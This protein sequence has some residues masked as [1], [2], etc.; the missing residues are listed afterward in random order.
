MGFLDDLGKSLNKVGK[1]TSEMASG[2]KLKLEITKHKSNI[3]KK[4][5]ELGARVYFLN[6]EGLELDESISEM[7]SAIDDM[8]LAIDN[9]EKEIADIAKEQAAEPAANRCKKCG[10]T[11]AEDTKFCGSCGDK[12]EEVVEEVVEGKKLCPNCQAEVGEAKF[13][14]SCG[15]SLE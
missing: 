8:F 14:N 13:C 1:K 2:A 6:K 4:Y 7:I 11:L 9:L 3:D 15:T 5:E 10:A 12:V